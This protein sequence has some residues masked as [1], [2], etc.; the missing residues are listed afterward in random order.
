MGIHCPKIVNLLLC[1]KSEISRGTLSNGF[2]TKE[3]KEY[4]ERKHT[5]FKDSLFCFSEKEKNAAM[6]EFFHKS[7]LLL[8]YF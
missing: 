1:G 5:F 7:F 8:S 3:K 6:V 4:Q 2:P